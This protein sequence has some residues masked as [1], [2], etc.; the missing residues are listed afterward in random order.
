MCST[1][2]GIVFAGISITTLKLNTLMVRPCTLWT[3]DAWQFCGSSHANLSYPNSVTR[4]KLAIIENQ[5]MHFDNADYFL[6]IFG[7][8]SCC[9]YNASSI[10]IADWH[11]YSWLTPIIIYVVRSPLELFVFTKRK[12]VFMVQGSIFDC[13]QSSLHVSGQTPEIVYLWSVLPF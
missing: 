12:N 9:T 11:Q 2:G 5:C 13:E 3:S 8:N 7:T 1:Q 6:S 10:I 4:C